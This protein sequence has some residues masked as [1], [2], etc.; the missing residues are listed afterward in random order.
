MG[1]PQFPTQREIQELQTAGQLPPPETARTEHG[2]LNLNLPSYGLA[3]I[4]IK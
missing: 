2:E 4:E 1:S 3:V